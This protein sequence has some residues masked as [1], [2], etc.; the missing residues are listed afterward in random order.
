MSSKKSSRS[1]NFNLQ[2][3]TRSQFMKAPAELRDDPDFIFRGIEKFGY[4]IM[5]IVSTRLKS[6]PLFMIKAIEATSGNA[7]AYA[8]LSLKNDRDFIQKALEISSIIY[9]DLRK[10]WQIEFVAYGLQQPCFNFKYL[11][12]E[13]RNDLTLIH[14]CVGSIYD[15][16]EAQ[17]RDDELLCLKAIRRNATNYRYASERLQNNPKIVM[18][19]IM[20]QGSILEHVPEKFKDDDNVVRTAISKDSVAFQFASVRL[21][22]DD[23]LALYAMDGYG[24]LNY[25]YLSPR[26]QKDPKMIALKDSFTF[27]EGFMGCQ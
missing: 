6:D 16:L 18:V 27:D 11:P 1:I 3:E 20:R 4:S 13:Y 23:V 24:R 19:A 14:R 9:G 21:R 5:S 12:V 7:F 26:L 15:L 22:D 25:E 10:K 2:F 8:S 17:Y